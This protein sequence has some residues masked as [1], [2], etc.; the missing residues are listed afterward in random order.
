[1]YSNNA[2]NIYKKNSVNFASKEQLLLMLLD[3]AVTFV[4][5][6]RQGIEEKNIIKAHE[7]IM[8]T[9]DIFIE[10]MATLDVEK[11]GAWA[12]N[13]MLVYE[14]IN[15]KLAKA[16]IKKSVEILDEVIPLIED[17]RDTWNEAYKLSKME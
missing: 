8:K 5:T 9:E 3:G 7:N 13:L 15:H 16:N 6:A 4:K 2:Y 17:I 10:L 12:G 14:F 1:M 11:G